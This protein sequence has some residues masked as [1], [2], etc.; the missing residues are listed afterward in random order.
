MS[1]N[2]GTMRPHVFER[3]EVSML[4]GLYLDTEVWRLPKCTQNWIRV[5]QRTQY[6]SLVNNSTN[7]LLILQDG[8][9]RRERRGHANLPVP[10]DIPK[11]KELQYVRNSYTLF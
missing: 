3:N 1:I 6:D 10:D 5:L 2:C 9:I 4:P 8:G 11:T 7:G